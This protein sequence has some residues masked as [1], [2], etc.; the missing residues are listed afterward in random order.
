MRKIVLVFVLVVVLLAFAFAGCT[1]SSSEKDNGIF[2]TEKSTTTVGPGGVHTTTKT[3]PF[4]N[5][6]C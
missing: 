3:C 4:W 1:V 5:P 2:G 6:N